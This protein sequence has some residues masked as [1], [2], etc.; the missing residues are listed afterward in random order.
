MQCIDINGSFQFYGPVSCNVN[1][2][3]NNP[4]PTIPNVTSLNNVYP[5]PFSEK[6]S[7]SYGLAKSELVSIDIFNSKGQ[8]VR[9]LIKESK[10]AGEHHPIWD[11]KDDNNRALP[12][13]IYF[14]KLDAGKYSKTA[15]IVLTK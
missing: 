6:T 5:N 7:I 13:G 12:T 4:S 10:N 1:L 9:T 2:N 14:I 8:K 3:N 11:G 15:K